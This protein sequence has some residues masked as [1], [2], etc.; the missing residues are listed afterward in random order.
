MVVIGGVCATVV[1]ISLRIFDEDDTTDSECPFDACS[2]DKIVAVDAIDAP[3]DGVLAT[4]SSSSATSTA[5]AATAAVSFIVCVTLELC[6]CTF[7]MASVPVSGLTLSFAVKSNASDTFI[8]T[9]AM[10]FELLL[11]L[12]LAFVMSLIVSAPAKKENQ[13]IILLVPETYYKINETVSTTGR[14]KKRTDNKKNQCQH[15]DKKYP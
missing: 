15:H 3:F 12:W 13:T 1:T 14:K 2:S 11:L 5:T 8:V 7:V 9:S 10:T 4:V 6:L